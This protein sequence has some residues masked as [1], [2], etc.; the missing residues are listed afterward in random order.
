MK[1]T[2]IELRRLDA[3]LKRPY[4]V[5][6][7]AIH[8]F[9]P[10]VV[11]LSGDNGKQG[12]GE[13]LI[14]PGYTSE[15]L[16]DSMAFCKKLAAK[17]LGE[18]ADSA[19]DMLQQSAG[20]QPGAVSALL[21]A[22]DMLQAAPILQINEDIRVPLLAPVQSHEPGEMQAEIEQLL[23]AGYT[24]LKVKIGFDWQEDLKRVNHVQKIVRGMA[25]L[26]LDAN[27]GYDLA[28]GLAIATRLNPDGIE[29]FEQPCGS[30]E[31]DAHAQI[32]LC[33]TVPLMLDESIYGLQDIV[34]CGKMQGVGFVKL[35]LKKIGSPRMLADALEFIR[36]Q[37]M[38]PVLGDGVATDIACWAEACVAARCI[39]SAGEM[40]GHLKLRRSLFK[41]TIPVRGGA[42]LIPKGYW[43][44][45]DLV[46][47]DAVTSFREVFST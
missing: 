27:R 8:A 23:A 34:R 26:R 22:L 21:S 18:D 40:N 39:R 12:W 11:G 28:S 17:M 32:G 41:N 3:P 36:Q 38:E 7:R 14:A 46:A 16:Q 4:V 19:K 2:E 42:M 44:Q 30:V 5:S 25:V 35:K 6:T 43:P 37:G 1:I 47:L 45:L 9:D 31:W 20:K 29:L 24:T 15:T 33:S 13:V 10:I